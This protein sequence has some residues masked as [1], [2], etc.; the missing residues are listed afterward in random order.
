VKRQTARLESVSQEL[1]A[2]ARRA[3]M[4]EVATGVLHNV[5]NV[6][7]SVN[8]ST[9]LITDRLSKSRVSHLAK[10]SA[11]LNENAEN[12]GLFLTEDPKGKK[13]PSFI[14]SLAERLSVEQSDLMREA[15][16]LSRNIAHI[17]DIVAVQQNYAKVSGIVESLS[18][19][20]LVEDALEMN[21]AAF[22]RHQVEVTR[23][24][25]ETPPV[26]VDKHK[27]LQV[28]V[29]IFS[30]A[31]Y[32]VS[33]S[34]RPDK[35]INVRISANGDRRVRIEV[36]DNGIG[37]A[38]ENLARIFAHGFTTKIDGHGFG[39]HSAALAATETGG[40]LSAHSD[41][42]NR[43]ATFTLELPMDEHVN[44]RSHTLP[45]STPTLANQPS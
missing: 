3:G 44:G 12:L 10:V 33:E 22:D 31:K 21:N 30:N 43:G 17:K 18:P 36:S 24:F 32:A 19:A 16:A 25:E 15:E 35:R 34:L 4:A 26:R 23:E 7:N 42:A 28:L 37:I 39:L 9:L 40:S 14:T 11:L 2:T 5:G 38:P 6:L 41:G 20:A 13:L 8:V 27:V 45:P 1:V 29:N